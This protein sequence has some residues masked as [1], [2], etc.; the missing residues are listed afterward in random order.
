MFPRS[1]G[2]QLRTTRRPHTQEDQRM[3]NHDV[4]SE[5]LFGGKPS[6]SFDQPGDSVSGTITKPTERVQQKNFD[7]GELETW[8]DGQPKYQLIVSL[9]TDQ[10]DPTDPSD[11]GE[12]RLF[13]AS[14]LQRQAIAAAVKK[15]GASALEVGGKLTVTYTGDGERMIKNG[16][17]SGF[18]P[19]LYSATY[20]RPADVTL[21]QDAA[22]QAQSAPAQQAAPAGL[23]GMNL[24]PETLAALAQMAAA[25]NK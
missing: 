12:R 1:I 24:T 16:R 4:S 13:I 17:P 5:F 23:D 22:P 11:D 21:T 20:I 3:S 10:R 25:Q 9:S 19:K 2:G 14:K 6:A 7:S 8:P 15:A 18:P